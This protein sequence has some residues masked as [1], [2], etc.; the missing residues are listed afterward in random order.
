[1]TVL[2]PARFISTMQKNA[3]LYAALLQNVSQQ[4]A[5]ETWD[6]D[7]NMIAVLC[8]VR[9]FDHIF[10]ERAQQM[11]RED[12]PTLVPVD[13]EALAEEKDYNAQELQ[14]VLDDF[15]THRQD[16][17]TWFQSLDE[18]DWEKHGIHPEHGSYS[19]FE[20]AVQVATHDIDHLE[21]LAR[22]LS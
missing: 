13:H 14:H 7:W 20:Q 1:M 8:H 18:S 10:M 16:F 9:D 22:M 5:A 4:K 2:S 11:Q 21:Q 17:V 6:G 19:I 3:Q 12:N 15:I